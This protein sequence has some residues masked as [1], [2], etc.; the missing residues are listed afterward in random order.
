M[1]ESL[2][3]VVSTMYRYAAYADLPSGTEFVDL[4][5]LVGEA[6]TDAGFQSWC[7][8]HFGS[9]VGPQVS[10]TVLSCYAERGQCKIN[11]ASNDG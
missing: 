11:A 9:S 6:A 10:R 7:I 1:S 2:R 8:R 5:D 3:L 4:N